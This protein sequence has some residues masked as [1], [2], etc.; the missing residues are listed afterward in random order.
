M[1]TRSAGV[2]R[3]NAVARSAL[4]VSRPDAFTLRYWI[5]SDC[6]R[7]GW[8]FEGYSQRARKGYFDTTKTGTVS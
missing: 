8:L 7:D 1:C 6:C 3:P 5:P 4:A 2:A